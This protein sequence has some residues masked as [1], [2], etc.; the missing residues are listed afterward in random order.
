MQELPFLCSPDSTP[1][2]IYEAWLL[3]LHATMVRI[4]RSGH[5]VVGDLGGGVGGVRGGV[6]QASQTPFPPLPPPCDTEASERPTVMTAEPWLGLEHREDMG[7]IISWGGGGGVERPGLARFRDS[8]TQLQT[9][10][11]GISW[12][13]KAAFVIEYIWH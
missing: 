1:D 8:N 6:A 2:A 10:R 4:P 12:I 7:R 3:P 5:D 13:P 9:S 11:G